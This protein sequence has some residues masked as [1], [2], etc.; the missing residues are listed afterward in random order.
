MTKTSL[1][2]VTTA[3]N[4]WLSALRFYSEDLVI[5]KNRLTEIAGKYTN[6]DVGKM[7]EHY[8]N[9]FI[10]QQDNIARLAHD[11]NATVSAMSAQAKKSGTGHV[12]AAFAGSFRDLG[13]RYLAEEKTVN[14][15]RADFNQFSSVWM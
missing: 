12:D 8:Q 13:E 6:H 5:M 11:I 7:I 15:L 10:V 1:D 14:E 2:N 4:A 9:Q 3:H